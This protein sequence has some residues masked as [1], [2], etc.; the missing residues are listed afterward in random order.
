MYYHPM[1]RFLLVRHGETEDNARGVYQGHFDSPL[2]PLGV[3]QTRLVAQR[4]AEL[5]TDALYSSDLGRASATAA[6]IKEAVGLEPYMHSGLRERNMGVFQ[7]LAWDKAGEMYPREFAAYKSDDDDFRIPGGESRKEFRTRVL[8]TVF[9][10]AEHHP[11]EQV[12]V[13]THGGVILTL[14]LY[15]LKNDLSA[16]DRTLLKNSSIHTIAADDG[17]LYLESFGDITHL[18]ER[19]KIPGFAGWDELKK[20]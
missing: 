7:G 5:K 4:L 9:A 1:T 15:I 20:V 13:V 2:T 17:S 6:I 18:E 11:G 16:G 19:G 10:I 12:V 3:L 14:V 8:E